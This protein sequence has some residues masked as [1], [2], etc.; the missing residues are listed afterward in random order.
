[1]RSE[2]LRHL[3][4]DEG[5]LYFKEDLV[6]DDKVHHAIVTEKGES[7]S[8]MAAAKILGYDLFNFLA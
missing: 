2:L 5:E 4:K 3:E 8:Q 6:K 7:A 1:M